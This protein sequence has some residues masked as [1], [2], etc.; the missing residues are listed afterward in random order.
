MFF[1]RRLS[2]VRAAAIHLGIS[3]LI[4]AATMALMLAAWYPPPLFGA[5]GGKTLILL[6]VGSDVVIGPLLTLIVFDPR[7]KELA[8]DLTVVAL[9]QLAALGYGVH[10]MHAG[11]PA[12]IAFV[13]DRFAVASAAAIEDESLSRAR[14]EFRT[15]SQSGPVV[16]AV[17]M[18]DDVNA[19]ND[20]AFAGLGGLGAQHMPEYYVPYADR[21]AEVLAVARTLDRLTVAGSADRIEMDKALARIGRPLEE[22]RFV[23]MVTEYATL[24]ALID[25]KTAALLTTVAARP[26]RYGGVPVV[27]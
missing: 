16:V 18:P 5:M 15:L 2:R 20:I 19:L 25:A 13:T 23:P 9:L 1:I 3:A 4:A 8:A 24:T 14:P 27:P 12:V 10:A 7:K 17:K 11:R 6:I 22:L 21:A 26:V